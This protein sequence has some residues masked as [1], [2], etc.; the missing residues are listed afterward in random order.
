MRKLD[1]KN[2]ELS[3][4][5]FELKQTLDVEKILSLNAAQINKKTGKSFF[6][7]VHHIVLDSFI[8]NLCKIYEEKSRNKLN[9]LPRILNYI[10][11]NKLKP[12]NP[13]IAE[14]FIKKNNQKIYKLNSFGGPFQKIFK[15]FMEAHKTTYLD[16]KT[17]RNAKLAHAEDSERNNIT[18]LPC[19]AELEEM[20]FFVI[21]FYEVIHQTYIG[22]YP[23]KHKEERRVSTSL[24]NV[25]NAL[26]F[27]DI[28]KDY[29]N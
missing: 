21:D 14:N 27:T 12:R 19:F 8:I 7:L 3:K 5:L 1:A 10:Q 29:E 4:I 9:S 17:C 6:W 13:D 16:L 22:G 18:S 15:S 26:G 23:V 20:L 11:S 28:K 2:I 25:L 24:F